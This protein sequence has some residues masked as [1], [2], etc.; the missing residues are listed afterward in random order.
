[1]FIVAQTCQQN[2][3]TVT[4]ILESCGV[5]DLTLSNL[6]EES[7]S[8]SESSESSSECNTSFESDSFSKN[9]EEFSPSH[10]EECVYTFVGVDESLEPVATQE[11]WQTYTN[12]FDAEQQ[13]Q[14]EFQKRF[15]QRS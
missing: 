5:I 15:L 12:A 7:M 6:Q 2:N 10:E 4:L 11:E 13:Q 1:M 9:E 8:S 14:Q 3:P